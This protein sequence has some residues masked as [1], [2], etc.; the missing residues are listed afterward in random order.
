MTMKHGFAI[1]PHVF[2]RGLL[3]GPAPSEKRA[4]GIPG[5]QCTR[6]LVCKW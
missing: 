5:A 1:S 3:F 4:R 6:S 2:A